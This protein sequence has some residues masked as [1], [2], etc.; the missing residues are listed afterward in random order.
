MEIRMRKI[1]FLVVLLLVL[2]LAA[3]GGSSDAPAVSGDDGQDAPAAGDA[4]AGEEVF[5]QTAVPACTTC[6]SLEPGVPLVGPSLA[7][8][9]AEAG[10]RVDGVSA[11]IYLRESIT[12]PDSFVV[13]GFAS[14]LMTMDYETQLTEEQIMDLVAY[15]LTLK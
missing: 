4:V 2:G 13:E 10:S 3:C 5:A 9:G 8:I 7:T 12:A 1:G 6:H 15:M 14:G 11:E